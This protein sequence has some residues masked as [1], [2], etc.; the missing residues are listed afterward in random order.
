MCGILNLPI[1][2][3]H[4]LGAFPAI[5]YIFLELKKLKKGYRSYLG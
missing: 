3:Y 5:R 4:F 1:Y 2:N